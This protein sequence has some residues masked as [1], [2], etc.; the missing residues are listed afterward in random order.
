VH[1]PLKSV[2][3][4]NNYVLLGLPNPHLFFPAA[5]IWTVIIAMALWYRMARDLGPALSL[6][7]VGYPYPPAS[8]P[9]R[10]SRSRARA[11]SGS[12]ST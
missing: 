7:L 11:T 10:R 9:R 5:L 2:A 12:T 4:L 1:G 6:G 8:A 3:L